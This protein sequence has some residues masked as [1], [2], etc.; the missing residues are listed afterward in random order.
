[1]IAVIAIIVIIT[2]I[3]MGAPRAC[4]PVP[5]RRRIG[6]AARVRCSV[7]SESSALP[8]LGMEWAWAWAG[9][10]AWAWA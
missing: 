8:T 2:V 5:A 4:R 3:D 10:W 7:P 6:S 1:M 9:E